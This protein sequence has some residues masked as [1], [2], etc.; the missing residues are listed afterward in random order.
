ADSV[1]RSVER[2]VAETR[3]GRE[4]LAEVLA[5]DPRVETVYSSEAN[6]VLVRSPEVDSLLRDL[7]AGGIVVRDMRHLLSEGLRVTVGSPHEIDAVRDALSSQTT[8]E[9][10]PTPAAPPLSTTAPARGSHS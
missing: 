10:G 1:R 9:A 8:P 5:A 3:S 7:R 4:R 2:R 6:F